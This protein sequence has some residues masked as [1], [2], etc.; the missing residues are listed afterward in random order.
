MAVVDAHLHLFRALSD[1]YPRAIFEGMTPPEREEPAE[2]LLVA[3]KEAGVE[4]AVVVALSEHDEYLTEVLRD[5]PGTFAGVGVFDFDAPDSVAQLEHRVEVTGMQGMRFYGLG[6]DRGTDPEAIA[7]FPVLEA[8]QQAGLNVWFYGPPDQVEI[9]DG[10]MEFLPDLRVVMN[11]L[12]FCPDMHMELR[13]DED[14][15][16]RFDIDL[17]PD[18][19][20]L[21]ERLASRHGNLFVH[22]SGHYAFTSERYPYPDLQPVVERV[23][24]AFGAQRMLMASDWP[25]IKR[26][27]G[28]QETLELVDIHLPNLAEAERAMIRGGTAESLFSF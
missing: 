27:P 17:P 10:V 15:R 21:V 16:P 6:A 14:G 5:H 9:L 22:V 28:Y 8:M 13:I 4:R 12:G 20:E 7:V 19:L 24:A 23:H 26:N 2:E 18:S 1:E 11:H 3:M 25:W